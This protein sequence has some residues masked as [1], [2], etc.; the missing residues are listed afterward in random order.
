MAYR[1]EKS[2][3]AVCNPDLASTI[4]AESRP[5][6]ITL[7]ISIGSGKSQKT[8]NLLLPLIVENPFV[9]SYKNNSRLSSNT[10]DP[11]SQGIL[12]IP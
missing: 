9:G 11:L 6:G 1:F 8:F 12:Y 10:D 3:T 5:S 4:K 7:R 2:K